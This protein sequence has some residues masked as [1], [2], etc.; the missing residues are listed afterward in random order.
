MLGKKDNQPAKKEATKSTP[1]K[2]KISFKER[3]GKVAKYFRDVKSELKKVV[4]PPKKV[5]TN[6][7]IVVLAV[8]LFFTV[9]ILLID[10]IYDLVIFKLLLKMK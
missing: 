3:W 6:H 8:M 5:V 4:W 7:T 2:P 1:K 9:L 10:Q